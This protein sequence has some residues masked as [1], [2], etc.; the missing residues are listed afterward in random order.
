MTQDYVCWIFPPPLIV[1]WAENFVHKLEFVLEHGG[2]RDVC[3][4]APLAGSLCFS[5]REKKASGVGGAAGVA[6][7]S[8]F[9]GGAR[10]AGFQRATVM[11]PGRV[12][13]CSRV[14]EGHPPQFI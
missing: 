8:V 14:L 6:K 4:G 7:A 1:F 3:G 10:G 12:A 13:M 5:W 2:W 9:S 11:F